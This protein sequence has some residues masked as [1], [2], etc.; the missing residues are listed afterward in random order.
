MVRTGH[1]H[2]CWRMHGLGDARLCELA[3]SSLPTRGAAGHLLCVRVTCASPTQGAQNPT[4]PPEQ[5]P[6]S[7]RGGRPDPSGTRYPDEGATGESASARY[8]DRARDFETRRM[9]A[10]GVAYAGI[11][12]A[13]CEM[14]RGSPTPAATAHTTFCLRPNRRL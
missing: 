9:S 5:A 4:S 12:A 6:G 7:P 2:L 13:W 3:A 10:A 8:I 11:L 14:L 1:L